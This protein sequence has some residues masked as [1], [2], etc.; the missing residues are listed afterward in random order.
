ME[1]TTTPSYS[2]ALNGSLQGFIKGIKALRQGDP[3]S[4]FLFVLCLEYFSRMSKVATDN[5]EF[6]FHTKCG[7]LKI[8][9]PAFVDDLMLFTRRN[10]I[11]VRIL[12]E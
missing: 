11:S 1:C 2:I 10:V 5:S 6:N 9:H 7:P 12:M 8:T 3:L 4:P